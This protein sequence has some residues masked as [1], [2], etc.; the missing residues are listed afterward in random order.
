MQALAFALKTLMGSDPDSD[1]AHTLLHK[2][3]ALNAIWEITFLYVLD[4]A[5]Y[6]N[7]IN[8]AKKIT[9]PGHS[10]AFPRQYNT[11]RYSG[12]ASY[13]PP[14][15]M[16]SQLVLGPCFNCGQCGHLRTHCTQT[17]SMSFNPNLDGGASRRQDYLA[18]FR[19]P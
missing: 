9:N 16:R 18:Y 8:V 15:V 13:N 17:R 3:E 14:T 4:V 1:Q 10:A 5:K 11:F 2:T 7:L 6:R 12:A 19:K